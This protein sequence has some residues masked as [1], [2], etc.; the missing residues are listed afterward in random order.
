MIQEAHLVGKPVLC[1][2]IGGMAE[3]VSEGTSGRYFDP[4]KP[5]DLARKIT[6]IVENNEAFEVDVEP[7]LVR[8]AKAIE[9]HV[10]VYQRLCAA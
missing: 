6:Q 7:Q 4:G 8:H 5:S 2:R 9:R 3:K 10:Q 1:A